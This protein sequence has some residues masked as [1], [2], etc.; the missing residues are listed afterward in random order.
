MLSP[1]SLLSTALPPP[2]PPSPLLAA[3][4]STNT[5]TMSVITIPLHYITTN[6]TIIVIITD[7]ASLPPPA[8]AG[9]LPSLVLA[10]AEYRHPLRHHRKRAP[11]WAN[12]CQGGGTCLNGPHPS[13]PMLCICPL[14]EK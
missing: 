14:T 7:V 2:P 5:I 9:S 3:P 12:P 1:L 4:Y 13:R 8:E 10:D 11:C 6:P